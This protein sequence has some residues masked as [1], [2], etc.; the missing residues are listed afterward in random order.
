MDKENLLWTNQGM[1][2]TYR[3]ACSFVPS[4]VIHL[5]LCSSENVH[6]KYIFF[7]FLNHLFGAIPSLLTVVTLG[8]FCATLEKKFSLMKEW[9]SCKQ[10]YF[11]CSQKIFTSSPFSKCTL[12]LSPPWQL[13]PPFSF[14]GL[15][16]LC[17]KPSEQI[18]YVIEYNQHSQGI[19]SLQQLHPL[20]SYNFHEVFQ[21]LHFWVQQELCLELYSYPLKN[22]VTT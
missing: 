12:I 7:H 9:I 11:V 8:G 3:Y 16:F 6:F 19:A 18:V 5:T 10:I 17:T 14:H 2:W 21:T 20:W 4:P 22:N 1:T 13:H 15:G